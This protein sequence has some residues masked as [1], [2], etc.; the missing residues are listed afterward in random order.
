MALA[1]P[2]PEPKPGHMHTITYACHA[3]DADDD[4]AYVVNILSK[5][6]R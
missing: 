2:E 5:L 4:V 1:R 6:F 3:P